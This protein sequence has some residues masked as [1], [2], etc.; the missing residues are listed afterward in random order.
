MTSDARHPRRRLGLIR[1]RPR[2]GARAC[3]LSTPKQHTLK[4]VDFP[5]GFT[6]LAAS[7]NI[8]KDTYVETG[9]G[10]ALK[11]FKVGLARDQV[12][13]YHQEPVGFG[14]GTSN[15]DVNRPHV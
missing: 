14:N 8:L 4:R 12:L 15:S 1:P 7:N 11:R 6:V 2:R 13:V 9:S 5:L 10:V 3:Q